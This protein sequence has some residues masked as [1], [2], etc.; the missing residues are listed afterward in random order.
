MSPCSL[1]GDVMNLVL[2]T[3]PA[4]EPLG[5]QDVKDYLRLDDVT[6]TLEDGYLSALITAAREYCEGFQNRAY[7]TQTWQ[8]S[9]D[10]W[11]SQVIE[12]PKGS[13][14]AIIGVIYK[15][16]E[17]VERTLTENIDYVYSTRGIVGRLTP[18]K[19][20][21][22]PPFVPFPLDAVVIEY[23]CGYGSVAACVPAKAIQAMR[24]L[25]SHW[26]EHRTPLSETGQAPDEIAFA[27]SALLHMDRIIP[28]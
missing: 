2:T 13:L 9:F 21:T 22:W 11:P 4:I 1:K 8:L 5:L 3:P 10:D 14:Q 26:Y 18:A 12:L 27:V 24:L 17:G 7:I 23:T 20:K 6:D 28:T 25:V 16:S 19:N 15:N